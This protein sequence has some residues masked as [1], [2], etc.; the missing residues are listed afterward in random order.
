MDM[1]HNAITSIEVN[2]NITDHILPSL[3]KTTLELCR[4]DIL[5]KV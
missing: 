3:S 4:S 1:A 5:P 2:D